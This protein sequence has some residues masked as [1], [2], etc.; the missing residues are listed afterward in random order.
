MRVSSRLGRLRPYLFAELNRRRDEIAA[1]GVRVL[2]LGIGDPDLPTPDHVVEALCNA[3]YDPETHRYPPYEGTSEFREAAA[4]RY[5]RLGVELDPQSEVLAVIGSKEGIAHLVWA[6]IEPGATALVPDPGY[7]V[8][9]AQTLLCG[10]DVFPLP[11]LAERGFLPDLDA[12]PP[13]VAARARILFLNYPNNPTG[14]VADLAFME[15]AVAFARRHDIL[16]CHD[17]AYLDI[18]Y[19]APAPSVLQVPGARDVAVEFY[20]LSKPFNMTGWRLGFAA[21]NRDAVAA[22][23]K[24]KSNTDSGQFTAVQRAGVA[25]LRETDPEFS[26]RMLG[27]YRRRRDFVVDALNAAGWAVPRPPGAFYV[28]APVPAGHT[29]AG[30]S[31]MLLEQAGVV[32]SPGVAFGPSGEG[33]VRMSLTT[34]EPVLAEAIERIG[35]LLRGERK[36]LPRKG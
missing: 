23:A 3:A 34:P 1:R 9:S 4:E 24:V 8:Y 35:A 6:F 20:S 33:Y 25:A 5:A 21:G 11:L 2:D 10:G 28:F 19:D 17:A 7:P 12:V 14:A 30:F 22:L 29:S 16:L 15:R 13:E 31:T 36:E 26:R 18:S 32:V 27:V